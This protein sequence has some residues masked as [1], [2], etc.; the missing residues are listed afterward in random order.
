MRYGVVPSEVCFTPSKEISEP[1][2]SSKEYFRTTFCG[3]E[4]FGFSIVATAVARS[5]LLRNFRSSNS[6]WFP[7]TSPSMQRGLKT[8][9]NP[10]SVFSC[11]YSR[12]FVT[13]WASESRAEKSVQF[14]VHCQEQSAQPNDDQGVRAHLAASNCDAGANRRAGERAPSENCLGQYQAAFRTRRR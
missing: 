7:E 11:A 12:N 8:R 10:P 14:S 4:V 13:F 1:V 2:A 9:L 3:D 6:N 5:L